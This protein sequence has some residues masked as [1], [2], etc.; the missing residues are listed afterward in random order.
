LWLRDWHPAVEDKVT[1][2]QGRAGCDAVHTASA[3][4]CAMC[5]E[6]TRTAGMKTL[7]RGL[8][9]IRVQMGAR[10]LERAPHP[11]QTEVAPTV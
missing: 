11:R 10:C 2:G 6:E 1:G 9:T 3:P 7:P 8:R 4:E 5:L